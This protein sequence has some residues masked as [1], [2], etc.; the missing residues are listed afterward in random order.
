MVASWLS[1]L[2]VPGLYRVGEGTAK[3]L[4]IDCL[5]SWIKGDFQYARSQ[6]CF[7]EWTEKQVDSMET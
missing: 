1:K 3:Y 6:G 4:S 5:M 2:M 7:D